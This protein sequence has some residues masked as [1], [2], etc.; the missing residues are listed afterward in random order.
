MRGRG[1]SSSGRPPQHPTRAVLD[2][3]QACE[4]NISCTPSTGC[5][6]PP[7]LSHPITSWTL[8][9]AHSQGGV[10]VL[11][12]TRRIM[13]MDSCQHAAPKFRVMR[14]DMHLKVAC[15]CVRVHTKCEQV[16][17]DI[18]VSL[19]QTKLD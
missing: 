18:G 14:G 8:L 19:K 17:E 10:V 15:Q 2:K 3:S 1:W 16:M 11:A 12:C 9:I 5:T 6:Y 4:D 7:H 13:L